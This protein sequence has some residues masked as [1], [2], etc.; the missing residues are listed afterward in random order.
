MLWPVLL[1]LL[2][3]LLALY[4]AIQLALV[5]VTVESQSMMPALVPGDRVLA[6]RYWPKRW[7]KTGRVV[8]VWP[9]PDQKARGKITFLSKDKD[10]VVP[11]IKRIVALPGDTVVTS[12][13]E[14][15]ENYKRNLAALHDSTGNRTWQIPRD[16]V[17]VRGDNRMNSVDSAVWGPVPMRGVLGVALMSLPREANTAPPISLRHRSTLVIDGRVLLNPADERISTGCHAPRFAAHT[18]D[19]APVGLGDYLGRKTLLLFTGGRGCRPCLDML[20]EYETIYPSASVAG[21]EM[22][23]VSVA[24]QQETRKLVDEHGVSLPVIVAP[25]ADNPFLDDYGVSSLPAYC[26]M[27]EQGVIRALGNQTLNHS[28]W[29]SLI[30]TLVPTDW[31]EKAVAIADQSSKRA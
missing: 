30:E 24:D 20:P 6:L 7:L 5:V 18:L 9:W 27:D 25:R 29:S 23:L 10:K 11:F 1:S 15:P 14:L 16:H 13:N 3:V 26:L 21:I 17:F 12:I 19:G 31:P 28:M 4:Y 22:V 2:V 8:I